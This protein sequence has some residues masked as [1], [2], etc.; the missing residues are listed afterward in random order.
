MGLGTHQAWGKVRGISTLVPVGR[1][2][3]E[4]DTVRSE[5]GESPP[6]STT[7]HF[8]LLQAYPEASDT[9]PR[10]IGAPLKPRLS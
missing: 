8:F 5:P 10:K 1:S 7:E 2:R 3:Q 4:V 6:P 9:G